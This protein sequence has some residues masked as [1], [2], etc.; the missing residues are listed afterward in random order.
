MTFKL[1]ANLVYNKYLPSYNTENNDHQFYL[2][3]FVEC[4]FR[5]TNNYY[6]LCN[7]KYFVFVQ[8]PINATN[9]HFNSPEY[10]KRN[11]YF[12]IKELRLKP[13]RLGCD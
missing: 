11:I 2:S 6:L 13:L 4:L 8:L 1:D 9:L 10:K 12:P 7:L 5:K 3:Y